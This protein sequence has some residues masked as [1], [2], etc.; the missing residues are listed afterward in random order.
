MSSTFN[1]EELEHIETEFACFEGLA[2]EAL[3]A[4]NLPKP[5][6][7][8]FGIKQDNEIIA[9]ITGHIVYGNLY[10]ALL[11]IDAKYRNQGLGQALVSK[12]WEY[13]KANNCD[14]TTVCTLDW[15]AKPFYEKLG[16]ELEF[17]RSGYW[18]NSTLYYFKKAL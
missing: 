8:A 7:F 11:W 16:Y 1:I 6:K 4:K 13:G 5:T 3:A 14:F 2:V 10:I 12:A 9:G 17:E 15:Q 18:N